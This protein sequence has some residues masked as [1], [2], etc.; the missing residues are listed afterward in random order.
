MILKLCNK[1]QISWNPNPW[2]Y[3]WMVVGYQNGLVRLLNFRYM[4]IS[5]ELKILLPQ[6]VKS[7]LNKAKITKE[8]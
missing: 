1:F 7:M 6:H 3:L 4:S 2:S 8:C 5:R